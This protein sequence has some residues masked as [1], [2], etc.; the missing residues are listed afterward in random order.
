MDLLDAFLLDPARINIWLSVRQ[1]SNSGSGTQQDPYHCGL[2]SSTVFPVVTINSIAFNNTT[3]EAT[4]S[5]ASAHTL[6]VCQRVVVWGITG[7]DAKFFNGVFTL[8]SA[9]GSQFKYNVVVTG[10]AS[11]SLTG[12]FSSQRNPFLFDEVMRALP[13]S[14]KVTVYMAPGDYQTLGYHE[15]LTGGWQPPAGLRLVG[16]GVDITK[17]KLV[18]RTAQS[19]QAYAIG[20]DL[21]SGG[22]ANA[23]DA[24]EISDLTIDADFATNSSRNL[25]VGGVRL[26]GNNCRISRVKL[27]GWGNA[28]ST[29][30]GYGLSV[31]T[32]LTDINPA[33]PIAFSNMGIDQCMVTDRTGTI[34]GITPQAYV[35]IHAGG[36]ESPGASPAVGIAPY[37]RNCFIDGK[38]PDGSV[39]F[40]VDRIGLSM[41]WCSGGSIES[42]QVMN[43][44]YGG[45]YMNELPGNL[46]NRGAYDLTVR[47]NG[48]RNVAMGPAW[49]LGFV[50]TANKPGVVKL[51]VEQN[52]IELT[53]TPNVA[54]FFGQGAYGI[55]VADDPASS[56]P[57]GTVVIRGNLIR[58]LDNLPGSAAVA[59]LLQGAVNIQ[60][61]ENLIDLPGVPVNPLKNQRCTNVTYF[62]NRTAAGILIRG[63]NLTTSRLY[64]ELETMADEALAFAFLNKG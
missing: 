55:V 42:C 38:A 43:I 36:K 56:Q 58:Y 13:A 20:H 8:T 48:Y 47:S 61:R 53:L 35:A 11:V 10:T 25:A 34:S 54:T 18:A 15:N 50:A 19:Q 57:Y 60:V 24:T 14:P 21:V 29:L 52:L 59:V 6:L 22:I 5:T 44:K 37:L 62:S 28:N 12:P 9:S 4:V 33:Q 23:K 31:I 2:V 26:M 45:P 7:N 64:D 1:D 32:A 17:I 16:A 30:V 51:Q 3:R 39:D 40:T 63:I 49:R 27:I 41:D 46:H